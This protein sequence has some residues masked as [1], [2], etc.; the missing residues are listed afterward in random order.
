[1]RNKFRE[2]NQIAQGIKKQTIHF[3]NTRMLV[4]A[5]FKDNFT[6]ISR[7]QNLKFDP[8]ELGS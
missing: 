2:S 7:F 6:K 5:F 4:S 8:L 3:S 1:M